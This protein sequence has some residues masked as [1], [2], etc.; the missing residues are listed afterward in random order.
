MSIRLPHKAIMQTKHRPTS[1]NEY[2]VVL[3]LAYLNF[4]RRRIRS[5]LYEESGI[6]ELQKVEVY[7]QKQNNWIRLRSTIERKESDEGHFEKNIISWGITFSANE[8]KIFRLVLMK[9]KAHI[10]CL[11][12]GGLCNRD[13]E[14]SLRK[15]FVAYASHPKHFKKNIFKS[16]I[17]EILQSFGLEALI[18]EDR[19][20]T[21][22]F[23]CKICQ[24][25]QESFFT[26]F[27]FSESN[28]NVAFEFGFA[29]GINKAYF[30]VKK[31]KG[32]DLPADIR[33]L[34][35]I[36]YRSYNELKSKLRKRIEDRYAEICEL[37]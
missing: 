3:E 36:E 2:V 25:I 32:E 28:L 8:E 20:R 24:D 37:I 4:W 18:W 9:K 1:I 6:D 34:D 5:D 26:V 29:L 22:H 19:T 13:I 30:I 23:D 12:T 16:K 11:L 21:G 35:H 7:H 33:D 17:C 10:P 15:V 14:Y 27:E 31:A